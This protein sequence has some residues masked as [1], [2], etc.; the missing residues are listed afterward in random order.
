MPQQF[1]LTGNV[2]LSDDGRPL[3]EGEVQAFDRDLPSVER[4]GHKPQRLGTSPLDATGRFRITYTDEQFREG[5]AVR[6]TRLLRKLGGT[7]SDIAADLSFHI[8]DK[9]KRELPIIRVIAFGREYR[10]DQIIFNVPSESDVSIYVD[11]RQETGTSEYETL[12]A[13]LAPIIEDVPLAELTEEDIV[14][15]FNELGIEQQLED[16]NRIEWLHRSALLGQLTNLP[17]EAFYGWGREN[18]P[19]PFNDIARF[20][21]SDL[22]SLVD[23][24][25]SRPDDE[26]R[27]ALERA[28]TEKIIP[29]ILH[30]R[31][32]AIVR[33]LKRR[34]QVLRS[35]TAQLQDEETKALLVGYSVTTFDQDAGEENLGLDITDN[36]G[37]FS[38]RFYVSATLPPDAPARKFLFKVQ[39]PEGEELPEGVEL[40]VNLNQSATDMLTVSIKTNRPPSPK[41]QELPQN[42]H[43]DVPDELLT[44][45]AAHDIHTLT[46]IR[47]S[48]G[49]SRLPD[50]PQSDP[51]LIRRLDSLADLDRLSPDVKTNVALIEKGYGSVL[52]I[53]DTPLAE[54][55]N[56]VQD[57]NIHL[58]EMKA[59]ELH[60][61]ARAQTGLLSNLLTEIAVN[62]ANGFQVMAAVGNP[63]DQLFQQPCGC[64]D[65]EAAVS[66]AAYL[67]ALLDYTLKHVKNNGNPIDNKIDLQFLE[68]TFHQPFSSLPTDCEAVE[69]QVRQVRL[70]IEVLRSYLGK[71]PL[72]DP[73]RE[74]ALTKAEEEYR[75]AAYSLLLS[76]IG[77]SYEEIR[78]ARNDTVENRQALAERLGIDL[79]EP[80]PT[81]PPGDELDQLFLDLTAAPPNPY[82]LTELVLEQRFGLV[83]TTRDP[84]SDG[85]KLGDEQAQIIR[86]Q[87]NGMEWG[88]NT[89]QNG[90]VYISLLKLAADAFQVVLY[91]DSERTK[92]VASGESKTANGTVKLTPFNQS[93][94]SGVFTIAYT[95]D[96]TSIS[97][98][99]IPILLSQQLHGLR[100]AWEQQDWLD[101]LYTGKEALPIID[102]DVI[103]PDD[104]RFPV[105]KQP[106]EPDKA[107]DLWIDRRQW[108]DTTLNDLKVVREAKGLP[109]MLQQV[110]GNPLPDLDGLWLTLTVVGIP[111]EIKT[112]K[113]QITALHLTIESF[114]R[115]MALRAKDQLATADVRN[116]QV[117]DDEWNEV[118]SILTEVQKVQKFAEW[119]TIEQTAS[120][121]LG[122]RDFW[123][124]ITEPMQGDWPPPVLPTNQPRIDPGV[125]KLADVPDWLAGKDAIAFWKARAARLEQ[126]PRELKAEREARGFDAMLR[127]ALGDPAPGDPPQHDLDTLKINLSS[128]DE[129]IRNTAIQQIEQDLH[130]SVDTFKRLMEIKAKDDQ[131]DPAKKPTGEEWAEVYAI[132]TPARKVKH[133]YPVWVQEEQTNGFAYWQLLKAK[134]PRWR[135]SFEGRLAWQRA[136]EARSQNPVID[137]TVIG[138][139]DLKHVVVGDPAFDVWKERYDSLSQQRA[140]IKKARE[141]APDELAGLDKIINDAL[142]IDAADL[143]DVDEQNQAGQ[144]IEKRLA[145][146]NLSNG[147][148]TFLIRTRALVQAKQ[149]ITLT[150]WDTV[151]DTLVRVGSQRSS[152]TFLAEE[153]TRQILLSP[154]F[155]KLLQTPIA[156]LPTQ[157]AALP[158]WLSIWQM[159]RDWQ[160]TL[161][162]RID[163]NNTVIEACKDML[164]AVEEAT[165]PSL[166]D[167]LVKVTDATGATPDEQATWITQ[168]L[169]I[170]AKAGG[171]QIT[172]RT[173]QAIETI[174]DLVFSLRTGQLKQATPPSLLAVRAVSWGERRIDLFAR[175]TDNLLW[176]RVW[177]DGQWYSW[178]SLGNVSTPA[179]GGFPPSDPAVASWGP[180]RFDV[181]VC[182]TDRALWQKTYDGSWSD[183]ESLG[184]EFSG[185]PAAVSRGPGLID[186]F[187]RRVGDAVIQHKSFNG[188]WSDWESIGTSSS[189][190][191][192]ASS[193]GIN[194]L[195]VFVALP[196]PDLFRPLHRWWDGTWHE[197]TLDDRL[198]SD[199]S[200]VSWGANRIDLFQNKG[201]HLWHKWWDGTWHSWED[202]DA[203]LAG[204]DPQLESVPAV[205][206]RGKGIL[207]IFAVRKDTLWQRSFDTTPGWS[208]W[209][210][211]DTLGLELSF[212]PNLDE[213]WTW[214]GSY[215][216]WR[217]AMFVFLYPENILQPSLRAHKTPA[218]EKLVE[219]TR[220]NAL[221]DPPTACY[222]ANVYADY[223]R[224]VCA[225]DIQATCQVETLIHQNGNCQ[226]EIPKSQSLFYIFGIAK[227]GLGSGKLYWSAVNSEE[228]TGYAQSFWQPVPSVDKDGKNLQMKVLRIIGALPFDNQTTGQ[229]LIYLFFEAIEGGVHTL[230]YCAFDRDRFGLDDAW[231]GLSTLEIQNPQLTFPFI[232]I[233]PVQ[234]DI[235]TEA[236]RLA[237]FSENYL[238][239]YVRALN[240]SGDGWAGSDWTEVDIRYF[241]SSGSVG[242]FREVHD[243]KAAL[244]VKGVDWF[245][246]S[247]KYL[248]EVSLWVYQS[249]LFKD[250]I[251]SLGVGSPLSQFRGALPAFSTIS[252]I[253]IFYGD[254][255]TNAYQLWDITNGP[256]QEYYTIP[257]LKQIARH[258]GPQPLFAYK[259]DKPSEPT[260]AFHYSAN[261]DRLDGSSKFSIVPRVGWL[262]IPAHLS[263]EA[264][265]GRRFSI[266]SAFATNKGAPPAVLAYL[267]EACYF[268]PLQ[269]ALQMQ[270]AG[271]YLAAL[272]WLRTVYDYEAP[273]GERNIYYGLELDA[274]L[275][276]V[277]LYQQA[278][279]WLLDPL[280]PHLIAATRRYAY[281]RFTIMSLV[282]C[283]LDFAD[284]EFTQDTG[285]SLAQAR[286]L[287]LTALDLLNV[288]ELQQKLGSCEDLIGKLQ[289]EPGKDIPPEVPAVVAEIQDELTSSRIV[290]FSALGM[291]LKGI[292]SKLIAN[293]DWNTRLTDARKVVQEAVVNV[294]L[295]PS[296]GT[297][298]VARSD[299]LEKKFSALLTQPTIDSSVQ[300]VGKAAAGVLNGGGQAVDDH[301]LNNGNV[302]QPFLEGYSPPV[303]APSFQFCIPPNPMLKTLRLRVELSLYKLRT[304]RNI[305]GLKR[306]V[307]A[308]AAPT[309][310]TSGLPTIGAAGQLLVPG[311]AHLQPTPYRY[312]VLIERAKQLVQLA[313]QIEAQMFSTLERRDDV[314]YQLLQAQQGLS[315]AEAGVKLQNLRLTQ[316]NDSVTLA[317]LQQDR[318][319][320]Q[321]DYYQE[322]LNQGLLELERGAIETLGEAAIL[323]ATAADLQFAAASVY[324]AAAIVGGVAG[325]IAGSE[326]GPEGTAAGAVGG[327][328]AGALSGGLSGIASGLSNLSGAYSGWAAKRQTRA[329]IQQALASY[330][331][332]R[333]DWQFQESLAQQDVEIGKQ[334]TTLANDQVEIVK[335]DKAT[336]ELQ[337]SNAKDTVKFLTTKFT[338]VNLYDWMSD[339][340]AGVYRFFLQ[341]AT[342]MANLAEN[343]LAFE[344]Q[345]VPPAYIQADYWNTPSDGATNANVNT[346]TPDRRGLTGSAR[347]LQDIYQLDQYA[348]NTNKR[349]LQLVKTISLAVLAPAE[350]QRFRETGVMNFATPMD[351]FDRDF[352]GHYLRL[353]RRVRTSV[354]ALIPPAQGIHA[355]LSTTG[356]SRVVIGPD[357]FQTVPIRRDP[358]F[359]AL[360]SPTNATGLF[361]MD[362]LQT[363]MLLP[364]EGNGVDTTWE[365]RMPKAANQFDYRTIA[366]VLI[367]IEYTALNSFDYQQ[368]VIQSLNPNLSADLPF[369]FRNQFADQWYDLHN[370][371]QTRTPMT[372]RFQTMRED[373]PPNLET[374]KIQQV[375][376]YFAR[377]NGQTFELP[378][379]QLRFT[380]PGNQGTVG[381]SATPIDGVIS[382]RRG[383]AGSWMTMIGKVPVGEWELTLPNTE[384]VRNRFKNEEIDDML[385]VITY[386][387]RTPAWP[388]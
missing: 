156:V 40:L 377:S 267:E 256:G 90:M 193:W 88:E 50:L 241:P 185:N 369:S 383:N 264:L 14:F 295:S 312:Q 39:T 60:I 57:G 45:L 204:G 83:D 357:V 36:E 61:M 366:D 143:L 41:L 251:S 316:A 5:E 112:A 44:H 110:L 265:Q 375:L 226:S 94:L 209:Q 299:S 214:I 74:A 19:A 268:V 278:E 165:L 147:A 254:S 364:F 236:P 281:T 308:Y 157:D 104:F 32:D 93:G 55:V 64:S 34:N 117:S 71:R 87:V 200:A 332:R 149:P 360:S 154:D 161:Q 322:L 178:Q 76:K 26:L 167:A 75:F 280:N 385:F 384:E 42:G 300:A 187:T 23:K 118:Y 175:S 310:T 170:D 284:A 321:V 231:A 374:L 287:Y 344:R 373:F 142:G 223:F 257:D 181:F 302:P 340:L 349:K 100:S 190:A 122:L 77:T 53:A 387:G 356:L 343:Q 240:E 81:D 246:Y 352:P 91:K 317:N 279:D 326:V 296:T 348:F 282:R 358:E 188:S 371:E 123:M 107:F 141:A 105:K 84:L 4:R 327:A 309:D 354:I 381:G 102:P 171:C 225:L 173:A 202:V 372:V 210:P 166:R 195:D 103:G 304:C 269:L 249:G 138:P 359:V 126:I 24:I 242:Q 338:N 159:R 128:Q 80:R 273:L 288:P 227:S 85:V 311:V 46:D 79:T 113:E 298:I 145:Q 1:I 324:G 153:R 272:D 111:A 68:E 388:T 135:A 331:R 361:E 219:D 238:R 129:A 286:T 275:P 368:Q 218:F 150:E 95:A 255:G 133:E 25:I 48:G 290:S 10:A 92:P 217:A 297:V 378:V 276:D 247:V 155:F 376:L 215:A 148:F 31:V 176:H 131:P 16:Q 222:H 221:L 291:I 244:R 108:V 314:A 98:V 169:L 370:S 211:M 328:I 12:M 137:P 11:M 261:G 6:E 382:T 229:K 119:I 168:H 172:T 37:K 230:K 146:L 15:L 51:A 237:I 234:S 337:T 353:I 252:S 2:F 206:S 144:S 69:Q 97:I 266:Q 292:Q 345:E 294:P 70:C 262:N 216:T 65:C 151:Y 189:R 182:G 325:A 289:V 386:A 199:A 320:I 109:V 341:Q 232:K 285:E 346:P 3:L 30:D 270:K 125:I 22:Q 336:A 197:E 130:L 66:P 363:D 355:T 213:E 89:D 260:F 180:G 239:V 21:L 248:N 245:V 315:L 47:R 99:V 139:D 329:S 43:M 96:S 158:A 208:A 54:F 233:V 194:R 313:A 58:G 59:T 29:A 362:P 342:A 186:V 306:Q 35:V 27:G 67:A 259:V 303:I 235:A 220:S 307:E 82:A 78:R 201:G 7:T 305:A 350:F 379:T 330:E 191:P 106:G 323:Q 28:I 174:Q 52:T 72:T 132:L 86:W 101:D 335:Q 20:N 334:Q 339:I 183:W 62:Q 293:A 38:F 124:A 152:A 351:L 115:L 177:S 212:D 179:Q 207:D 73:T 203:L 250:G 198:A 224:D 283:L 301:P 228:K 18:V 263:E 184:G 163:Q 258:S 140:S 253:Y 164:S 63:P 160:D 380:A 49:L 56:I 365:F 274:K 192:S 9:S 205:C 17:I 277:S 367:T 196:A 13:T 271:Q 8:F 243:L 120:V 162:S 136:L 134:L 33:Q 333:Q 121:Q 114:S 347:L 116:E 318:T 319:Q 127:L